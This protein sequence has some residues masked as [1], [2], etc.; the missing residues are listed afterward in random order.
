MSAR[1]RTPAR[2]NDPP[3]T[4]GLKLSDA[5]RRWVSAQVTKTIEQ[6]VRFIRQEAEEKANEIAVSTEEEVRNECL[7]ALNGSRDRWHRHT[8]PSMG[9]WAESMVVQGLESGGSRVPPAC[10]GGRGSVW[11]LLGWDRPF[12]SPAA[13]GI[14]PACTP[15]SDPRTPAPAPQFNI[16]KLQMVEAEKKRVKAEFERREGAIDVKKKVRPGAVCVRGARGG[17]GTLRS[18]SRA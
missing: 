7:E 10:P 17:W 16:S 3:K 5:I 13:D 4:C 2:R 18:C 9:L 15:R 6:M 11:G 12:D 14:S 8:L 1:G